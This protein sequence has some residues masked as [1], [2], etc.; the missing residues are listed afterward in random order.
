MNLFR[1]RER[2]RDG[3][4]VD[5]TVYHMEQPDDAGFGDDTVLERNPY[6]GGDVPD[7]RSNRLL[8]LLY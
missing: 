1:I 4:N 2:T 6:R 3:G 8:A 7:A 5:H